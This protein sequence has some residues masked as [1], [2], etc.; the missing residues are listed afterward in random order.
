M[1]VQ[2]RDAPAPAM[3]VQQSDALAPAMVL[4][5]S[6][7]PAPAM[8]VQQSDAL[9]PAMVLQQSV[10]PAPAMKDSTTTAPFLNLVRNQL[11]L[12]WFIASTEI[13]SKELI[14][15][16]MLPNMEIHAFND[17]VS[18]GKS[19]LCFLI[20]IEFDTTKVSKLEAIWVCFD[21]ILFELKVASQ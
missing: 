7:A 5:Q 8:V 10:A 4:Q 14:S 20:T 16:K 13:K 15:A 9:A 19:T 12:Y 21:D 3:V 2:Q 17:S 1:K 18:N 11:S 6:V